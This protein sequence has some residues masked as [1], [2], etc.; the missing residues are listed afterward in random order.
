[1]P[2]YEDYWVLGIVDETPDSLLNPSYQ[3]S[4]LW[5][6]PP[7]GRFFA[8]P[9]AVENSGR[10]YLFC[11]EWDYSL[12]RGRISL[13]ESDDLRSFGP[14]RP[15]IERP[16]HLSYPFIFQCEQK[17]YCLPEQHQANRVALYR[18]EQFPYN[19]IEDEPLLPGFPGID[20]TVFFK[21]GLWWMFVGRLAEHWREPAD[22]IHL[23]YAEVLKGPWHSHPKNPVVERPLRARSAG[24]I[25]DIAGRLIRP[26]Q[27]S[28]RTYGGGLLFF[29]ITRISL[30]QYAERQIGA[31]QSCEAW[32][33]NQGLHHFEA[34]GNQVLIDAKAWRLPSDRMPFK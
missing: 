15:V 5:I 21:D 4:P 8:D 17:W 32:P 2:V 22:E 1:M 6:E 31:W 27:D 29:E 33:Y 34:L 11:E 13:L 7:S 14:P 26:V 23:F 28:T 20:P 3:P 25:L 12:L 9:F 10:H 19:W 24:R 30:S 16:F 18:A